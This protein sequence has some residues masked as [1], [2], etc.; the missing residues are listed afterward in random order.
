M[1]AGGADALDTLAHE[2]T[3]VFALRLAGGEQERELSKMVVLNEGLARWVERQLF[4]YPELQDLD[5]LQAAIVSKRSLVSP[6][7]LTDP[8]RLARLNDENLKYPLGAVLVDAFVRRYGPEAPRRLLSTLGRP[9]FPPRLQGFELW[10][11]AFQLAGFDLA[12]TLDDYSTRLRSWERDYAKV[13][14]TL[15]RPR[16]VLVRRGDSFGVE[17]RLDGPVP[18]GWRAVVRFRPTDESPFDTYLTQSTIE[19]VA[20]QSLGELANDEVCFQ[21]GL[22]ASGVTIFEAWGCLPLDSASH[23]SQDL[24][25][26]S[27]RISRTAWWAGRPLTP[28]PAWVADEAWY[29]PRIGVR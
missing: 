9:D 28:P 19:G 8:D 6:E 25:A 22:E 26:P 23:R 17:V 7:M 27:L 18:K 16:G 3:H 12:L 14:D 13:I 24:S 11:T 15:P 1:N 20:W 4:E 5:R 21:P 10:Q 2:T 29:R